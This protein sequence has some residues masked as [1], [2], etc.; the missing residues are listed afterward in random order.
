MKKRSLSW[1][2]E[3]KSRSLSRDDGSGGRR[4]SS[5]SRDDG[6][7]GRRT[8]SI[9][10]DTGTGSRISDRS[11]ERKPCCT[12][13]SRRLSSPERPKPQQNIQNL[14]INEFENQEVRLGFTLSK[15]KTTKY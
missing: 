3:N 10:R 14:V 6:S 13:E 8:S 4:T 12:F 5:I 7:G 9:S 15:V 1:D 11:P 2:D